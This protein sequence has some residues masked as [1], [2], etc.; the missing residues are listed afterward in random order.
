MTEEEAKKKQDESIIAQCQ[1]FC[2]LIKC[3]CRT[4]CASFYE[5]LTREMYRKEKGFFSVPACCSNTLVCGVIQL[6]Q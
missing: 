6:D 4:D 5:G 2:P 1:K 3:K